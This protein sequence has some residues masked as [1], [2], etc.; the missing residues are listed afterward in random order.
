[1]Y[2]KR[3]KHHSQVSNT[4]DMSRKPWVHYY[5]TDWLVSDFALLSSVPPGELKESFHTY[6]QATITSFYILSKLFLNNQ[7]TIQLYVAQ[8]T[9]CIMKQTTHKQN[10]LHINCK[11]KRHAS[12]VEIWMTTA[13]G[14]VNKCK[15]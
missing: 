5:S 12:Q 9:D 8:G 11:L 10:K 3:H 6:N 14:R 15:I 1:M 7:P 2:N 4:C 13:P